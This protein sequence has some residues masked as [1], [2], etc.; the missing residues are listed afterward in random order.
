MKCRYCGYAV[1]VWSHESGFI[2]CPRCGVIQETIYE[3]DGDG[4]G[5][6]K[7][8]RKIY[9][10]P[11]LGVAEEKIYRAVSKGLN[12]YNSKRGLI[13][14]HPINQ[15]LRRLLDED[16]ELRKIMTAIRMDPILYSRTMRARMGIAIYIQ[17]ILRGAP[18][19]QALRYASRMSGA[20]VSTIERILR[21]YR[22]RIEH[23]ISRVGYGGNGS[24]G[25]CKEDTCTNI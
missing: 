21:K 3:N 18:R 25:D 13:L 9:K 10:R 15:K 14:D 7:L 19:S 5:S 6:V 20:S 8:S 17:E 4:R 23:L 16:Q 11:Y 24:K 2:V 22:N 1:L 12:V